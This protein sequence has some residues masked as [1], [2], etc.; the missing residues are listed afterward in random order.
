MTRRTSNEPRGQVLLM[1][2]FA[3]V[4][5]LGI[6]ALAFDLGFS[7]MLHRKEQNA[8]DPGAIAAAR[9]LKDSLGDTAVVADVQDEMN[10]DACFYAQQNGFFVD[11]AGCAAALAAGDLQVHSPPISGSYAG[12]EGRVQVII[13]DTHP[14][15]FA[16]IWGQTEAAVTTAAVAANDTGNSNSSSLVALQPVCSGGSAGTVSGG[17]TVEIFPLNPTQEGGYVHVNSPCGSS[18]NDV[19]DNG[20]GSSALAVSGGGTLITPYAYVVG[21]CVEN[22]TDPDNSNPGIWCDDTFTDDS[23]IDEGHYPPIAD[24]LAGVPEPQIEDFPN[25]TCPDGTP[26]TP[27]S[28]Q[29]CELRNG[30]PNC[31]DEVTGPS[32]CHLYPGVY[33][34]GWVVGSNVR[35][36]LDPGLYILAG[37]GIRLQGVSSSIEAVSSPSGTEARVTIFS[38]DGP[39]CPGIAAQCQGPIRFT[40]NQAFKANATN[41]ASCQA[42]LAATGLN[43]CPWKGIL[44]WQDGSV[45]T[46]GSEVR[47]GGQSSTILAGTIYAPLSHVEI[48]GGNNTTGCSADPND[49]TAGCLAI[50]IISYTWKITGGGLL[51]MPYDP[52][53]LYQFPARGLIE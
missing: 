6:L 45:A 13:H 14:T 24:P 23:C 37:G 29:G 12:S 47:L 9:W 28:T 41:A 4:V 3:L 30:T 5:L 1:V 10:A 36:E 16:R 44:V 52:A 19:C 39:G 26:S 51:Q 17:G 34:G 18:T 32:V 42:V 21:T 8:A 31:P 49:P 40:A 2:A 20:S 53:G 35:V 22:G 11:D 48:D 46:P 15:F 7:W 25:A 50:Q 43:I 33:Y 38:T 27:A